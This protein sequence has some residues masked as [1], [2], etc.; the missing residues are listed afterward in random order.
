VT[1]HLTVPD[2]CRVE[3]DRNQLLQVLMILLQNAWDA[4]DQKEAAEEATEPP[5][6]WIE[7]GDNLKYTSI[8]IK[9]NGTGIRSDILDKVFDPFFT[10]KDVGKGVGLGLSIGY[11]IVEGFGGSLTVKSEEGKFAEF[12]LTLPRPRMVRSDESVLKA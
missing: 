6:I 4:L 3:A 11:R 2:H 10:T 1:V 7:A 9:D 12:T 5:Q 8:S